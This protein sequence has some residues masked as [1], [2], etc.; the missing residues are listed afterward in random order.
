MVIT[1]VIFG[2]LSKR[3]HVRAPSSFELVVQ[4]TAW[5]H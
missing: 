1:D 3:F 2:F 5:P 4:T